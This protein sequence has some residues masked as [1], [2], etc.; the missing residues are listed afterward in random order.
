MPPAVSQTT[1][2]GTDTAK[3]FYM[4][5]QARLNL[6]VIYQMHTIKSSF[7]NEACCGLTEIIKFDEF[8][9][10][11]VIECLRNNSCLLSTVERM[12]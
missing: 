2:V 7:T 5:K 8:R 12:T 3:S 1:N 6:S 4:K 9:S 11:E 10:L